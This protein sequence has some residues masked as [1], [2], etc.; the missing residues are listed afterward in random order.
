MDNFVTVVGAFI[1]VAS[2]ADASTAHEA[3]ATARSTAVELPSLLMKKL[4]TRRRQA[5]FLRL[6]T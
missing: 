1:D 5:L 3:A 4:R 6:T 2:A